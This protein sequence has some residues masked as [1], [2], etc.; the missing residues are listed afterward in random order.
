MSFIGGSTVYCIGGIKCIY[1]LADARD[2][3]K[4]T[5]AHITLAKGVKKDGDKGEEKIPFG[6]HLPSLMHCVVYDGNTVSIVEDSEF[7]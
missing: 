4:Y 2:A 7:C 5:E 3:S 1:I 6:V